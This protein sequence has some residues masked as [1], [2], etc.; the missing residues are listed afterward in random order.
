MAST[1]HK[2]LKYYKGREKKINGKIKP[3]ARAESHFTNAGFFGKGDTPKET[4]SSTISSI[5]KW[6]KKFP[7]STKR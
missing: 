5:G 1:L 6:H 3:F 4:M 7:L 2:C